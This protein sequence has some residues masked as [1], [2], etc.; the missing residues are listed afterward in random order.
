MYTHSYDSINKGIKLNK[1]EPVL[2]KWAGKINLKLV[3]YNKAKKSFEKYIDLKEDITSKDYSYLAG[4][5][6]KSGKLNEALN[7]FNTAIKLD[8]K[9]KIAL[10]GKGKTNDLLNKKLASDV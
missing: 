3:D 7:F 9:N 5:C 10:E 1:K 6:L 8:P 4:A 2:Y